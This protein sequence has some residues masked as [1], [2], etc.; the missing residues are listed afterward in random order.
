MPAY[1]EMTFDELLK[2]KHPTAWV[3]FEH[4]EINQ[5]ELFAKFFKDGRSFDGEGLVKLMVRAWPA[6]HAQESMRTTL[7]GPHFFFMPLAD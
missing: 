7:H 3:E 2:A 4:G 1:F 6:P 5:D